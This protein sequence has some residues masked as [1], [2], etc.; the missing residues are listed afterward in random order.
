[1]NRAESTHI[2][3]FSSRQRPDSTLTAVQA[4]KPKAMP[5][6]MEKV[7]GMARAATTTGAATVRSSQSICARALII[8]TATNSSAGAV[9]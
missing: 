5:L 3:G 8:S 4:M 9:A 2:A 7:S 1:M 6:A